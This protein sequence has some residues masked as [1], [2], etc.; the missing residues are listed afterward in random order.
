MHNE[1][2]K[3]THL[4]LELEDNEK[5]IKLANER[6][7]Q[8]NHLTQNITHLNDLNRQLQCQYLRFI[9]DFPMLTHNTVLTSNALATYDDE[10]QPFTSTSST[11]TNGRD[12]NSESD[13]VSFNDEHRDDMDDVQQQDETQVEDYDKL[14]TEILDILTNQSNRLSRSVL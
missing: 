5:N 12:E 13:S 10:Q 7:E 3:L 4:R 14:F 2:L 1:T 11:A 6:L 9:D 8:L